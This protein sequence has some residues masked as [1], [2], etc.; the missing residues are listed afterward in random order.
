MAG[1]KNEWLFGDFSPLRR[2]NFAACDV[3][4]PS[5]YGEMMNYKDLSPRK[6]NATRF[7]IKC[8]FGVKNAR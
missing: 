8:C 3:F 1:V 7:L 5:L 6:N 4:S 2:V